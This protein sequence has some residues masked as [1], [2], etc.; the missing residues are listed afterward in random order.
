MDGKQHKRGRKRLYDW[1]RWFS[2]GT[3]DL[4]RGKHY[5]TLDETI[6]RMVRNVASARS[7]SASIEWMPWGLRVTV[8]EATSCRK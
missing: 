8:Q 3:F 2:R 7:M 5:R 4:R 6:G 1:E